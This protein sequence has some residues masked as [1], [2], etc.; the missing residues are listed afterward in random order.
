MSTKST[1]I[2]INYSTKQSIETLDF[3]RKDTFDEILL[4]LMEF[5]E[6]NKSKTEISS[7][8]QNKDTNST[9]IRINQSTKE[10]LESL[11]FVRKDTFDEI[12]LKL[13]GCYEK[14]KR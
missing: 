3:V 11:D 12:L 8:S 5:Y 1:T 10:K 14:N 2:R 7:S 9:T 6:K 4:K 13:I